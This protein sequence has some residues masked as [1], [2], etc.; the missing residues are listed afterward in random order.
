LTV[1]FFTSLDYLTLTPKANISL[2]KSSDRLATP[3]STTQKETGIICLTQLYFQKQKG[4]TL[5]MINQKGLFK[6]AVIFFVKRLGFRPIKT[7]RKR[8]GDQ[9]NKQRK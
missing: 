3:G 9:S 1:Q 5:A 8:E 4:K 7:E 2:P 6:N